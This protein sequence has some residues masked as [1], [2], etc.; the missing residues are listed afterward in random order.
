MAPAPDVDWMAEA[1]EH[2]RFDQFGQGNWAELR[3]SERA[4]RVRILRDALLASGVAGEIEALR[5]EA[6]RTGHLLELL[7]RRDRPAPAAPAANPAQVE[8]LTAEVSA[9][10]DH[11]AALST[12]LAAAEARG[13]RAEAAA[14]HAMVNQGT[15]R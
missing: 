11:V 2:A 12:A 9:L 7:Q 13:D 15:R 4:T 3:E 6:N 14:G 10:R 1:I 8:Q 5:N